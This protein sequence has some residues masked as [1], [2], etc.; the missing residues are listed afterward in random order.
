MDLLLCYTTVDSNQYMEEFEVFKKK[1]QKAL[2]DFYK[3]EEKSSQ[4]IDDD[5]T[6]IGKVEKYTVLKDFL[7]KYAKQD[8]D[9]L[10]FLGFSKPN[11]LTRKKLEGIRLYVPYHPQAHFLLCEALHKNPA[12]SDYWGLCETLGNNTCL[13]F[14]DIQT[15][16]N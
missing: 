10:N 11:A 2:E 4:T 9:F 7:F 3:T 13:I 1:D 12:L 6:V 15:K 5:L 16:E 8:E 14:S